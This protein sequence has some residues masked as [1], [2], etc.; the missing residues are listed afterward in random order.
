DQSRDRD[1]GR[2]TRARLLPRRDRST[3][4]RQAGQ[5]LDDEGRG[6]GSGCPASCRES[7]AK[8][9]PRSS[10]SGSSSRK[11]SA[12]SGYARY[13]SM[14]AISA[15][16]RKSRTGRWS[17]LRPCGSGP[18]TTRPSSATERS[19]CP[20]GVKVDI[21]VALLKSEIKKTYASV[22]DEPE[23]EFIFP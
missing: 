12:S 19:C 22:S 20:M 10:I 4:G 13:A 16:R 14:P 15:R 3:A 7:S 23:R 21:D 8:A 6:C 11:P 5:D 17:A 2:R 1:G 18:E 9:A